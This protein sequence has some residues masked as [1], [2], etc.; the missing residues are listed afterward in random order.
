M[1]EQTIVKQ[2]NTI[3]LVCIMSKISK[4]TFMFDIYYLAQTGFNLLVKISLKI[5]Q[6]GIK[7]VGPGR[8]GGVMSFFVFSQ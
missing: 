2:Q 7:I 4:I 1:V 6:V 8:F 3:L 5:R